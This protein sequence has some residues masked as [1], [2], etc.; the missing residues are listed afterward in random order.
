MV[1]PA[2]NEAANIG[3][4]I[5]AWHPAVA[6][7]GSGGRLVIFDDG[8]KDNTYDVAAALKADYPQLEVI[9]KANTGHGATCLFAYRYALDAGADY[10]FQTDSDGQTEPAEFPRFWELRESYNFL[11]G[12]RRDRQDGLSRKLVT[13]VLRLVLRA[14]FGV[15]VA[16]ANTPF[17]L[18]NAAVLKSYLAHMPADFF[19][20]NA[21][22]SAMAVKRHDSVKWFPI[23]FRPR[24]GGENS[25]NMKRIVRIGL[26]AV[27]DFKRLIEAENDFLTGKRP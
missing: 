18:M 5:A 6:A 4:V 12:T 27:G 23:T 10:V 21:L 22:L 1:L 15:D 24:Q 11:I 20:A 2:Y 26:K 25:I 19:L 13:N 8:S 16:D 14:T 3:A 17:R 7:T 9:R